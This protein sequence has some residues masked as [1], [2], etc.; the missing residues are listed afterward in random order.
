[1]AGQGQ[2]KQN[3][4]SFINSQAMPENHIALLGKSDV[5]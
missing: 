2:K 5:N 4:A 3:Q 1:M